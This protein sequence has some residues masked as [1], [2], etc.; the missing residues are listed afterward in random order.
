MIHGITLTNKDYYIGLY[1]RRDELVLGM[2]A[3]LG[4][5]RDKLAFIGRWRCP[6]DSHQYLESGMYIRTKSGTDAATTS[7]NHI[8][9][10]AHNNSAIV[11]EIVEG[12]FELRKSRRL[13]S[14]RI[15]NGRGGF[16]TEGLYCPFTRTLLCGVSI[17]KPNKCGGVKVS[18]KPSK[19]VYDPTNRIG[20]VSGSSIRHISGFRRWMLSIDNR[21]SQPRGSH[22]DRILSESECAAIEQAWYEG[23]AT[24]VLSRGEVYFGEHI[25]EGYWS[26]RLATATDTTRPAYV[27]AGMVVPLTREDRLNETLRLRSNATKAGGAVGDLLAA[28]PVLCT[29]Q[30]T[31]VDLPLSR[32]EWLVHTVDMLSRITSF[33][34]PNNSFI[35][36]AATAAVY[37]SGAD[38]NPRFTEEDMSRLDAGVVSGSA[39]CVK[40]SVGYV[41]PHATL[42]RLLPAP[43]TRSEEDDVLDTLELGVDHIDREYA[44]H[45]PYS[46]NGRQIA[47]D[48]TQG[49][50]RI[51][52]EGCD[53]A[54][55]AHHD[56]HNTAPLQYVSRQYTTLIE[57]FCSPAFKRRFITTNLYPS[58]TASASHVTTGTTA[59]SSVHAD[60]SSAAMTS[61]R[62]QE[63]P[64]SERLAISPVA[65]IPLPPDADCPS[66][67]RHTWGFVLEFVHW[68]GL[69]HACIPLLQA[70]PNGEL[71]RLS[72]DDDA[73][74]FVT[75]VDGILA[76]FE[77]AVREMAD[78]VYPPHAPF[79]TTVAKASAAAWPQ[80]L[81]CR[82]VGEQLSVVSAACEVA[83]WQVRRNMESVRLPSS[84]ALSS[85]LCTP[86]ASIVSTGGE[87]GPS[88]SLYEVD[89]K[90]LEFFDVHN[91]MYNMEF[92]TVWSIAKLERVQND[93]LYER[94]V[95]KRRQIGRECRVLNYAGHQGCNEHR[96]L[97]HGTRGIDPMLIA[98]NGFDHRYAEKGLFGR[99]S[100]FAYDVLYSHTY[101]HETGVAK[102]AQMFLSM[103]TAG[104]VEMRDKT[105]KEIKHPKQGCHS[106]DGPLT[107]RFRGL[108]VYDLDQAY[109]AYL[110]TYKYS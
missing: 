98:R 4:K 104:N 52:I 106:V 79:A 27:G 1:G 87:G 61:E 57:E 39:E 63:R 10:S 30:G 29:S 91:C 19:E 5:D 76:S 23:E 71:E 22:E 85:R 25:D 50:N 62:P 13:I 69:R 44:L 82:F 105:D 7:S 107:D 90:S 72:T 3:F 14:G 9:M 109:P 78:R 12:R 99:A 41:N 6:G 38:T 93:V 48:A 64:Q 56:N 16:S 103:V 54:S 49:L 42:R 24:C 46:L 74:S 43:A 60:P 77:H 36:D 2:N 94:Y 35:V 73:G 45:H 66:E 89:P 33:S 100:Y 97:A 70:G 75:S 21:I 20:T 59:P 110:V 8:T 32:Y 67:Y 102:E 108:M 53:D 88:V 84:W 80:G 11:E 17:S 18:L 81:V 37:A 47:H 92:P 95:S 96:W 31:W 28:C 101:R 86:T 15:S 40:T 55:K 65:H 34:H 58:T 51:A 83:M 26:L 68:V